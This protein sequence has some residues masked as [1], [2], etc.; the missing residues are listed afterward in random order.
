MFQIQKLIYF[1]C[2]REE[3]V[4][5]LGKLLKIDVYG[6]CGSMQCGSPWYNQDSGQEN[7]SDCMQMI[8]QSY[9][10]YLALENSHCQVFSNIFQDKLILL[11]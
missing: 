1:C 6:M 9:K 2:N 11:L 3:I 8:N 5:S 10:F 4:N 7:D